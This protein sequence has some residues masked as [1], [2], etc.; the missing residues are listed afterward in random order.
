MGYEERVN[1]LTMFDFGG[2]D[3]RH[4]ELA[5]PGNASPNMRNIDL[6]FGGI[7]KRGGTL[8]L[9]TVVGP[10]SLIAPLYDPTS[11]N[12][13]LYIF[14]AAGVV[15]R[16]EMP[17]TFTL[18]TLTA[19]GGD[20]FPTERGIVA[21][22]APYIDGDGN[23]APNPSLYVPRSDGLPLIF[24]GGPA[25]TDAVVM[26]VGGYEDAGA[27][28][29]TTG[30][31]GAPAAWET[32]PPRVMRLVGLGRGSRLYAAGFAADP[33]RVDYSEMD[34]P[35][36]FLRQDVMD[37]SVFLPELDGGYF[38]VNKGDDDAIVDIADM[39]G[40]TV[41]LMKRSIAIYTGDP[42]TDDH[43]QVAC[44]NVGCVGPNA[45]KKVGND[46]FFWSDDGPRTLSAVQEYGDLQHANI[47]ENT[48]KGD[49]TGINPTSFNKIVCLHDT[50]RSRVLWFAPDTGENDNTI[51]FAY[52]YNEQRF[53]RWYGEGAEITAASAIRTDTTRAQR[54][55]GADADG[56]IVE[57]FEYLGDLGEPIDA[58]YTTK[59]MFGDS[60]IGQ[61][62]RELWI[63]IIYGIEGQGDCLIEYE[64]DLKGTW[65]PL[66][67]ATKMFGGQGTICGAFV[68]GDGSVCGASSRSYVRYEANALFNM[69]RLRFSSNSSIPWGIMGFRIEGRKKGARG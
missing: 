48:I 60:D 65:T 47:A 59:W 23:S 6:V 34:V 2:L 24:S 3:T 12:G 25:A 54:C 62:N 46:I 5:L 57:M 7:A 1:G 38:Y 35:H 14:T 26:R 52:Y 50:V 37:P 41:I 69:I 16:T 4:S 19:P 45:W 64:T 33:K 40:Y 63:D 31:T 36:N 20:S 8:L 67:R 21:A 66:T 28:P 68:C 30:L 61:T 49:V 17:G 43:Q 10:A 27:V 11:E 53:S 44:Y 29:P 58:S 55:I 51:V 18:E 9:G 42:G 22:T 56:N 13:W 15:K 32:D 39:Y